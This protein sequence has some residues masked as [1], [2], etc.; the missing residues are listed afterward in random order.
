LGS[1]AAGKHRVLQKFWNR[2]TSFLALTDFLF[3]I[4]CVINGDGLLG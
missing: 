2:L 4:E 1:Y 3:L